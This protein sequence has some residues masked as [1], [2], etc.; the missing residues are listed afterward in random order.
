MTTTWARLAP[1]AALALIVGLSGCSSDT[2]TRTSRDAQPAA[3][4]ALGLS[5]RPACEI[6]DPKLARAFLGGRAIKSKTGAT[7]AGDTACTYFDRRGNRSVTAA[8]YPADGY[9]RAVRAIPRTTRVRVAG[10][11]AAF[12]N[13][14]GY[15]IPLAGEPAYL[16]ATFFHV[17][18]MHADARVSRALAR[19]L[20]LDEPR[21]QSPFI[22]SLTGKREA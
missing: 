7:A 21:R 1:L 22:C 6:L 2:G 5:K 3:A 17:H 11:E 12:N 15:L 4:N 8:L 9:E 16:Q 10:Y 18:H 13:R 19:S 14:L 20:L